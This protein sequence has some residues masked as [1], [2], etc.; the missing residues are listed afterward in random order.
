M[1]FKSILCLSSIQYLRISSCRA[2]F[3]AHS[4]MFEPESASTPFVGLTQRRFPA[5]Y[6]FFFNGTV[7][8]SITKVSIIHLLLGIRQAQCL[9]HD[10]FTACLR[11]TD[12]Q[13]I[14][15][16]TNAVER[17]EPCHSHRVGYEKPVVVLPLKNSP[18]ASIQ[19][20]LNASYATI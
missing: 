12:P 8:V 1:N 7:E 16:E 2:G 13:I 9:L 17:H 4:G 11:L 19:T 18:L 5:I 3:G 6:R 15:N 14:I 10:S 20:T